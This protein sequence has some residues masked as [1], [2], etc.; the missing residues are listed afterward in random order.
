MATAAVVVV[1]VVVVVGTISLEV[2]EE[3]I[4]EATELL[5]ATTAGFA[6][7]LNAPSPPA[8]LL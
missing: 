1:V 7:L 8:R 6:T 5:V 3:S 4:I 2:V